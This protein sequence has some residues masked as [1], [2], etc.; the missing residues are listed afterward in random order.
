MSAVRGFALLLA[1]FSAGC[2]FRVGGTGSASLVGDDLAQAVAD[3]ALPAGEPSDLAPFIP[4][5]APPPDM[6]P[7]STLV[8]T[9]APAS[10]SIDL[11]QIGTVDW[12]HYGLTS[13]TSFDD[14]ATGG[15]R[16]SNLTLLPNSG[17]QM[18][19]TSSAMQ[20]SWTDGAT[21]PG[22]QATATNSATDIF[23]TSGGQSLTVPAGVTR[24]RLI[25]YVGLASVTGKLDVALSDKSQP[26]YTNMQMPADTVDHGFAYTIDFAANSP[27]QTLTVSWSVAVTVTNDGAGIASA[28][29]TLPPPSK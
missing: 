20:F 14:K 21:G 2:Q 29:L 10:G 13:A 3:L 9:V 17:A 7:P 28:A 1:C 26:S 6:T 16:I 25:V 24:Q 8:V 18:Q 19:F 15:Q 12:A 23:V 4:D 22:H 27:G 5:L 11:T